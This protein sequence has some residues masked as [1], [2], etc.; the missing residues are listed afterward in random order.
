MFSSAFA[1]SACA[2]IPVKGPVHGP[3]GESGPIHGEGVRSSGARCGAPVR[4]VAQPRRTSRMVSARSLPAR[5]GHRI[6]WPTLRPIR[7]APIGV[8]ME[9][10]PASISA[11]PG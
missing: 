9:M 6:D 8:R 11:S 3:R 10:R 7:A 1:S 2:Q 4:R 5:S